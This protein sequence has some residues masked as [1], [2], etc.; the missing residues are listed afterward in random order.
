M[1]KQTGARNLVVEDDRWLDD[2]PVKL[3]VLTDERPA[4]PVMN[5]RATR[6]FVDELAVHIFLRGGFAPPKIAIKATRIAL[7]LC[8]R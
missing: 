4:A 6:R 3:E 2:P 8:S 5:L 7:A 1:L